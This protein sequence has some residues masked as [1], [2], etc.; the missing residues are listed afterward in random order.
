[1][2]TKI[3]NGIDA[4]LTNFGLEVSSLVRRKLLRTG[5]FPVDKDVDAA[6]SYAKT[7]AVNAV[8][9]FLDARTNKEGNRDA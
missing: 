4:K 5:A 2:T 7:K 9:D 3:T 1:M 8:A 6:L